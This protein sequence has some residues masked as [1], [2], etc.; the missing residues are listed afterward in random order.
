MSELQHNTSQ[1]A[2]A[3]PAEP[4]PGQRGAAARGSART[5]RIALD[6][7]LAAV[8]FALTLLTVTTGSLKFT[9]ASLAFVMAALLFGPLDAMAVALVGELL[10]QV[11]LYGITATTPI[12]LVPPVLHALRLGLFAHF[13]G[14]RQRPLENR[15]AAWYFACV[16]CGI[17]NAVFNTAAL[18]FDSVIYKYYQ[19]HLVFGL[20]LVRAGVAIATAVV[21]ATVSIPLARALRKYV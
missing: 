2:P 12:W 10:Y 13:M 5:R 9:F 19:F 6:G 16:D 4:S 11:I 20:A 18:Y 14:N 3:P 17:V 21:V 1:K 7:M 15:P 8:Y